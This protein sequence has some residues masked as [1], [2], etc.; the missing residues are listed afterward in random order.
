MTSPLTPDRI[1]A[2]EERLAKA[3]PGPWECHYRGDGSGT[4]KQASY[5]IDAPELLDDSRCPFM[6]GEVRF[7]DGIF[8][9]ESRT[10]LPDLLT[11]R[12]E[13]VDALRDLLKYHHAESEAGPEDTPILFGIHTR[14]RAA[15]RNAG[16]L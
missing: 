16:A 14:A 15:L 7:E 5:D 8:A 9:A 6:R 4:V 11:C 10:D 12:R 13:L 3:T 1:E 2:M